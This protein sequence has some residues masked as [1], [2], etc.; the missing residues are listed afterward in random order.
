VTATFCPL[1]DWKAKGY[2]TEAP[3]KTPERPIKP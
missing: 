1:N 2:K 3:K